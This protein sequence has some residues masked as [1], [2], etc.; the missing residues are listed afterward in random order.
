MAQGIDSPVDCTTYAHQIAG[1]YSFIGR[2][3]RM[4]PPHS[5]WPSLTKAE[6]QILS[7]A[8]LSIVSLWEFI[9][10]SNGCVSSLN[11]DAGHDEG[12]QAYTQALAIPQPAST[13][14]YF[15]VDEGYDPQIPSD[16]TPIDDY[17]RGVNDVFASLAGAGNPPK[18]KVGVYGP[19]AVCQWLKTNG[20]VQYTWLANAP[21]WPGASYAGW[22]IKQGFQDPT[23]ALNHDVDSSNPGDVGFWQMPAAAGV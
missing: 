12:Q 3:Y 11:Y 5:K 18:Y 9:S 6:A 4:P 14:I 23:L 2:Y 20:R 15:A 1:K 21:K 8:G 16:A 22:N 7:T 19:G 13:P 10:G 17:F